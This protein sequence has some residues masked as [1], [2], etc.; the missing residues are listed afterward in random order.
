MK[1]ELAYSHQ[2]AM[3]DSLNG[4]ALD[5]AA[6]VRRL[7]V[8]FQGQVKE[9]YVL[10]H[11]LT[12]MHE[13]IVSDHRISDAGRW[14]L[15]PVITVH[16][17]EVFFEAFST[18]ESV[19]CRLSMPLDGFV[20]EDEPTYGTTNIDFTMQLRDALQHWRSSRRTV[21][22]ISQAGFGVSTQVMDGTKS[23]V[24]RK[25][26]VPDSWIKSFLQVQGAL[27]MKAYLV[28]ARPAELLS[29]IAYMQ[30]HRKM[31]KSNGLRFDFR[32]GEPVAIN[33]E[34]S[35]DRILLNKTRYNGYPR[36]V[37]VW[38]RRRL[39]LLQGVL[40]HADKVTIGL[41]GRGMPHFY[42]CECGPY[43]FTL[44]LSGWTRSDWAGGSAFDL[45]APRREVD[46][47]KTAAV[48]NYLAQHY[49][50]D[51]S[52]IA[53]YTVLGEGEVQHIL[54]ELCRAGRVIFDPVSRQYR[55]REL[56]AERLDLE[57]LYAPDPRVAKAQ[58]LFDDDLVQV[59]SAGPSE[60]RKR[61]TRATA[62]VQDGDVAYSVVVAVDDD[63]Q[64]R[65]GQ[66]QCRFFTNNIL[67]RGPCE[68]ILAARFAL[69]RYLQTAER[70][71]METP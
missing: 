70:S 55:L 57:A 53:V 28:E 20:V 51:L 66:C 33:V 13:V 67:S 56:F 49:A 54:F 4:S 31:A 65:F 2:T 44:V 9:P 58:Q 23:H 40:L 25:V 26:D 63:G 60:V 35:N 30:E 3:L 22:A 5:F 38:G 39:E 45:L 6:N 29:V 32:T 12:A 11:L 24:E 19:Y 41:I 71:A 10:R 34:P 46:L 50:A 14:V 62:S 21:F 48:Y 1:V 59:Q 43:R 47:E 68:H 64:I 27:A 52:T 15:D 36:M 42:I 18:D 61:E 7:P 17:D 69:D 16:P 37:R 8:A